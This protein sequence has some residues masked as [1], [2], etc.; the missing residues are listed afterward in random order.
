MGISLENKYNIFLI[1]KNACLTFQFYYIG[2]KNLSPQISE[3]TLK[4]QEKYS[5]N[6][7]EGIRQHF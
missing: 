2:L 5:K 1:P 7:D 6:N 4:N 3:K